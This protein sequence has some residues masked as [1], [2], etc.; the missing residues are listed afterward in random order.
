MAINIKH[1]MSRVLAA[2]ILLLTV[3]TAQAV[4]AGPGA[5]SVQQTWAA[6]SVNGGNLTGYFYWP[7]SQPTLGGKRALVLVL[8]GCLQTAGGDVINTT[9]DGGY[10]W[11]AAADQY[12]AVIVAP[13]ATG[14]V[15]NNHC[16]DYANTTHNRSAAGHDAILLDLVGRFVNDPQLAIDPNQVYVTG[17]SSGGGETMVLGCLAPDIFAGVG[18]NAGPPP[19]TTTLQIGAVPSGYT[20]ATAGSKCKAMA[21]ANAGAFATQIAGAVWGTSDFT[22]AQGYGPIDTAGIRLAYGGSYTKGAAVAVAGGGSNVPYIDSNGKLRTHEITVSGMG[23]AWPAGSGGQ[24]TNYVDSTRVNYPAFVMDFWFKNNLRAPA[25]PGPEMTSCGSTVV[26]GSGV[27]ISGAGTAT[28]G[29]ASYGVL[30]N[31]PSTINDNAAGSGASFSKTY[32]L[33]SGYYT[34]SVTATDT[35]GQVSTGCP[36]A[37]FLVGSAPVLQP[38]TGLAAGTPTAS[39]VPLSWNAVSGAS[40]YNVYRNGAKLTASPLTATG[41]TASGLAAATTYSFAVSAVGASSESALSAAI[42]VTTAPAWSC[43]TVNASNYAHVQAGRAHDS[44]GYALAN[45]SNQNMGLDNL[46]YSSVLAQTAA[47]YYIIGACP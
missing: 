15:Y 40:G 1:L 27:T 32:N 16:W 19:G 25:T 17:L 45:G 31:G 43:T 24:N 2:A 37:Q 21:G 23:H 41:Y 36:L 35:L 3:C 14:N 8:H 44:G 29:V 30:L 5:W 10:N 7:A 28:G 34:G 20:A 38:P 26:S 33:A 22:V 18:I 9:G 39:S 11:K 46:F 13:N 12:G 42:N 47:G 6:D 4:T